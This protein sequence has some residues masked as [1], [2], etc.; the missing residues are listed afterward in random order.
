MGG[1]HGV[2]TSNQILTR[3]PDLL[4]ACLYAHYVMRMAADWPHVQTISDAEN[5]EAHVRAWFEQYVGPTLWSANSVEQ[6]RR[7]LTAVEFHVSDADERLSATLVI[8]LGFSIGPIRL[9]FALP[10]AGHTGRS[11]P[12]HLPV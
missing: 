6:A 7:P 8:T 5:F 3:L 10:L 9:N 4:V 11:L 1:W 2:S 12:A